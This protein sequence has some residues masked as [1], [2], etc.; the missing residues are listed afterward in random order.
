MAPPAQRGKRRRSKRGQALV[1]YV[2]LVAFV[3]L[4]FGSVFSIIRRVVYFFWICEL[5]PR[6]ASVASCDSGEQCLALLQ[7][8]QN[9][10]LTPPACE[11]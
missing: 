2:L 9:E 1:E 6:V 8:G 5:Y 7:T 10:E 11:Y 3:T 4:I